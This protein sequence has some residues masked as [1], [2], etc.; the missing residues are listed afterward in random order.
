MSEG[1]RGDGRADGGRGEVV[2]G[3][4]ADAEAAASRFVERFAAQLVE[5]GMARMPARVFAALLS[6]ERGI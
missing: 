5:A 1:R 2:G 4:A 6:S 3:G